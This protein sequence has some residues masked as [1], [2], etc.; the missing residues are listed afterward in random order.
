LSLTNQHLLVLDGHGSHITLERVEQA[1]DFGLDMII[2]PFHTSHVLQPLDVSCFKPFKTT[3]RKVRNAAMSRNNHMEPDKIT[4]AGW[5][6]QAINQ[7]LIKR[8]IKVGFTVTNIWPF[9]PQ[10]DKQ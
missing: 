6:N 3:F 9:N 7:S 2:L 1:Q 10:G 8:N 4:L 5:V